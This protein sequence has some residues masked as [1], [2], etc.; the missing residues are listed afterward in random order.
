MRRDNDELS[1]ESTG[2]TTPKEDKTMEAA[3]TSQKDI[4]R[5]FKSK[6]IHIVIMF[7]A[8]IVA[9][10]GITMF[11]FLNYFYRPIVVLDLKEVV[12]HMQSKARTMDKDEAIKMVGSYF[13]E[14]SK[15]IQTRKE[16]VLVKEAVLNAQQFKDITSEYKK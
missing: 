5:Y 1:S 6:A 4:N 13:D 11:V 16:V 12:S 14:M 3:S 15:S 7:L 2:T 8:T 9:S 10:V